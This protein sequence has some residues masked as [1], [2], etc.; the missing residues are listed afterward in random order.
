MR[1]G[2]LARAARC[3][4]ETIRYYESEGLLPPPERT[5]TNYR[6]YDSNHLQRLHF[7][8]NCRALDMTHHE[9]RTLLDLRDA[10]TT[11]CGPVNELVDQHLSLIDRRIS[12]LQLLRDEIRGLRD[13]CVAVDEVSRC[14]ILQGITDLATIDSVP[15]G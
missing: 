6:H 4:T 3:T 10:P 12:E 2:Q 13:C 14:K 8:R 1:I 7:I 5:P 9:I 15:R 11:A